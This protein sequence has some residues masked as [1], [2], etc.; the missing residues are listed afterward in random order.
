MML[1]M[2]NYKFGDVVLVPFPFT[3]GIGI[4]KRPAVIVSP[5]AYQQSRS[6]S[7]LLAITSRLRSPLA[8]GEGLIVDW[9]AAGLLKPSL[10]KPLLFTLEQS[11]ILYQLGT[12]SADDRCILQLVLSQTVQ[13]D[14]QP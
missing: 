4:K 1:S 7:V 6:D 13:G 8:Y 9:K 11:R 5:L 3:D 10:F 12:L 14:K 2:T